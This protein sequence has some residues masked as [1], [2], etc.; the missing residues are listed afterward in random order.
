MQEDAQTAHR[1]GLF[2]AVEW[3]GVETKKPVS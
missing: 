1:R 3:R 2:G